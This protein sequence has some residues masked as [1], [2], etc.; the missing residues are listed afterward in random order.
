MIW[1]YT[2]TPGSGKSLH[3][4][5]DILEASFRNQQVIANFPIRPTKK[6][7]KK[8][9]LPLYWDNSEITVSRLMEYAMENHVR[10]KEGQTLLIIDECAILFNCR[11]FNEKGRAE[12]CKF[13]SQ[14]RK[15]GY[16]IILITQWDRMLD[17]Q[18]RVM[19]EYNVVHRKANNFQLI[20]LLLT[21][22]RIKFFVAVEMWYGVNEVTS[23]QFF[24]YR[25]KYATI[26]DSYA[27]FAEF[28]E[29]GSAAA[30]DGDGGQGDPAPAG[31]AE[32]SGDE[33]AG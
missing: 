25:K 27:T 20:G 9:K 4:A 8:G 17:R 18:I 3:A 15:Y 6:Q 11:A 33:C 29:A 5:K 31:G 22:L 16:N 19:A 28:G 23:R 21:L 26:Y 30:A 24:I 7:R 13:F 1:M 32:L 14:H 12:W 10:G 2:G